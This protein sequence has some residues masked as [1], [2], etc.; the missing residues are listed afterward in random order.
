MAS[1]GAQVNPVDVRLF[2]VFG[3]WCPSCARSCER[4]LKK[5]DGVRE[6]QLDFASGQLKLAFDSTRLSLLDIRE[7]VRRL[8]FSLL[9]DENDPGQTGGAE[10]ERMYLVS[11]ALAW[12]FGM[13][14]TLLQLWTYF[15]DSPAQPWILMAAAFLTLPVLSLGAWPFWKASWHSLRSGTLSLDI[16]VLLGNLS[17]YIYSVWQVSLGSERV[18]FDSIV[19]SISTILTLRWLDYRLRTRLADRRELRA[20][21]QR[22]DRVRVVEDG[23]LVAAAIS[24]ISRG[25]EI[26]MEAGDRIAFDGTLEEGELWVDTALLSGESQARLCRPGAMLLAGMEV[27]EGQG[28]L[29]VERVIGERWIDQQLFREDLRTSERGSHRHRLERIYAY[30]LPTLLLLALLGALFHPGAVL[31]RLE[32][33]ALILLVGCPCL[34]LIA[35]TILRLRLARELEGQG[36]TLRHPDVLELINGIETLFWDKTGTLTR[37]TSLKLVFQSSND[38]DPE[39]LLKLVRRLLSCIDHPLRLIQSEASIVTEDIRVVTVPGEGSELILPNQAPYWLGRSTFVAQRLG[40]KLP[41][42]ADESGLWLGQAGTWLAGFELEEEL[43]TGREVL[44]ESLKA[45]GYRFILA[46]GDRAPLTSPPWL[47]SFQS[48]HF[49]LS[50]ESK[51]ALLE[52]WQAQGPVAF[53]GDGLNDRAAMDQADLSIAVFRKEL[54]PPLGAMLRIPEYELGRLPHLLRRLRSLGR[55]QNRLWIG[56]LFYNGLMILAAFLGF[57]QP[58]FAVLL[59]A[60][61]STATLLLAHRF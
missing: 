1:R 48:A 14:V 38:S 42:G 43:E 54:S 30:W 55:L 12:F 6:A 58:S 23:E 56:A 9:D 4:A 59:F 34:L 21:F 18:F 33:F 8:G 27:E 53:I 61:V 51:A 35:P 11:L 52:T 15:Q 45:D 40:Q 47:A 22:Q 7:L 2:R 50:P 57:L 5:K 32:I 29:R 16:V 28:R 24:Q 31:E 19:M 46:S 49:G 39:E 25:R 36:I 3:L 41:P 17:L 26:H 44:L 37:P 60:G 10:V 13:W 20:F